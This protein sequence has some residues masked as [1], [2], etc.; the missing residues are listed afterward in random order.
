MLSDCLSIELWGKSEIQWIAKIWKYGVK[1][2]ML[3]KL[4]SPVSFYILKCGYQKIWSYIGHLHYMAII[5]IAVPEQQP[6]S[7]IQPH[8][9]FL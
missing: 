3:L 2:S 8:Y 1:V 9:L 6:N 7:Q 4:S 5:D